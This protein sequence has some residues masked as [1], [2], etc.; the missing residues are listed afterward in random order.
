VGNLLAYV[1]RIL[2][3]TIESILARGRLGHG[4]QKITQIMR[5]TPT[6]IF[7]C[8]ELRR[9]SAIPRL[10]G[11]KLLDL[12]LLLLCPYVKSGSCNLGFVRG[13]GIGIRICVITALESIEL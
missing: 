10:L 12:R 8:Y 11:L 9:E 5:L 6:G 3:Q 4:S 13:V 2:V 7:A 1:L